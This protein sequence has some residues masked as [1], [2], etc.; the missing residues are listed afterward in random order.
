LNYHAAVRYYYY[1]E[2]KICHAHPSCSSLP[3]YTVKDKKGQFDILFANAGIIRYVPL[4]EIS[5]EHF[6]NLFDVNVKGVLFTVQK[7]LPILRWWLYHFECIHCCF[8]SI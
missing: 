5:Q 1:Y 2:S 4:P 8:Q 7:A 6:Y 3:P